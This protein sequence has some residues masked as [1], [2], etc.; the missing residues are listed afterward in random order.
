MEKADIER[1]LKKHNL[2]G[3]FLWTPET[4]ISDLVRD[5]LPTFKIVVPQNTKVSEIIQVSKFKDKI[6]EL[7]NV[8]NFFD[9]IDEIDKQDD[10]LMITITR[11]AHKYC[12]IG[13]V[14]N[15]ELEKNIFPRIC[16]KSPKRYPD[17]IWK[18]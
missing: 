2:D 7:G 4:V 6:L 17:H 1:L 15:H 9:D 11:Q 10:D 16:V 12:A 14:L 13:I 5:Y 3:K 8:I 18:K